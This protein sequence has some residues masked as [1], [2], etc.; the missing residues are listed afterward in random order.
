MRYAG[1]LPELSDA[2]PLLRWQGA[3]KLNLKMNSPVILWEQSVGRSRGS[4][5]EGW[6]L[7][8]RVG[9]FTI[10]VVQ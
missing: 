6:V 7:A 1:S 10:S 9:V 2:H 8:V 4:T 3:G 5:W